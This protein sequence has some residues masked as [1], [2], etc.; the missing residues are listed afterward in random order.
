MLSMFYILFCLNK[1][2]FLAGEGSTILPDRGHVLNKD[3]FFL[4]PSLICLFVSNV[5]KYMHV[6]LKGGKRDVQGTICKLY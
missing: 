6:Y 2:D 5:I 4:T 3:E 1:V